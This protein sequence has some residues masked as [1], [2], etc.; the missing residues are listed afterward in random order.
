[1]SISSSGRLGGAGRGRSRPNGGQ[2]ERGVREVEGDRAELV[3]DLAAEHDAGHLTDRVGGQVVDDRRDVG[4]GEVAELDLRDQDDRGLGAADGD[5]LAE[6]LELELGRQGLVDPRLLAQL[7]EDHP[8]EL[9]ADHAARVL[10]A[11]GRVDLQVRAALGPRHLDQLALALERAHERRVRE[12]QRPHR[13]IVLDVRKQRV[14][15]LHRVV[16]VGQRVVAP[17]LGH[18][19]VELLRVGRQ[20]LVLQLDRRLV[21]A[22]CLVVAAEPDHRAEVG[23]VELQR[24]LE[25]LGRADVVAR[26]PVRRAEHRERVGVVR[27]G[28]ERP[29][30]AGPR[31]EPATLGEV[32]VGQADEGA[33]LGL[34]LLRWCAGPRP[35]RR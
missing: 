14:Q 10:D 18:Q 13:V 1:M 26:A 19:R 35:P 17:Q 8:R 21:V 15:R 22:H 25:G 33:R 23:R 28:R 31:G 2:L 27:L 29:L 16:G 34:L 7:E 11:L 12:Q 24:L 9:A 6:L 4:Q 20:Q 5:D 30:G 3:H 32:L